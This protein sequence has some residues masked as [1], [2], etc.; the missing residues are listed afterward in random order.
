M[1]VLS[2]INKLIALLF[3]ACYIHQAFFALAA[4]FSRPKALPA[5]RLNRYAVLISARNEEA[6]IGNLIQSIGRQ[7]YPSEYIDK[8]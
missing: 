5:G 3:V 4:L 2:L 8:T 6:V 1:E 7:D